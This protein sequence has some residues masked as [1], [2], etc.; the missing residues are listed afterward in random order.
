[1]VLA[2]AGCGG[3]SKSG[4]KSDA[5]NDT[6]KPA[7]DVAI[8]D[9]PL[10]TPDRASDL[11]VP[12]DLAL[13]I[14]ADQAVATPDT[15]ADTSPDTSP[16]SAPAVDA[17]VEAALPDTAPDTAPSLGLTQATPAPALATA[18]LA[19]AVWKTINA[20]DKVVALYADKDFGVIDMRDPKNPQTFGPFATTGKVM[21]MDFDEQRSLLYGV[22]ATGAVFT[23]TMPTASA[24]SIGATLSIPALATASAI[25]RV[26]NWLYVLAGTSLQ[27]VQMSLQGTLV[28][29]LV[30]GTVVT[31]PQTAAFLGGGA[32]LL[33]LGQ[34]AG[35]VEAWSV[36][37]QSGAIANAGSFAAGGPLVAMLPKA[38]KLM[39]L[40][41]GLGLRV[42][43][44]ATPA[45]PV[46]IAKVAELSDPVDARLLGRMLVVA[47]A[48]GLVSAIDLSN[49][50]APKAIASNPGTLPTSLAV[51]GGNVVLGSG[52]SAQ[53]LGV[54]PM[55]SSALPAIVQKAMPLN[56]VVP[57]TFNKVIAP[58]S[59]AGVALTC[60]GNAIAGS[61]QL[62]PDGKT[63]LWKPAASLPTSAACS[64]SLAGITDVSGVALATSAGSYSFTTA[65]TAPGKVE[66]AA[67]SKFT[68]K[69]DGRFTDFAGDGGLSGEWSDVQP[70]QGMYTYFYADFDGQYLWILNDWYKSEE[71]IDPDCYNL[72]S[73]GLG[74]N[75]WQIRAYG[76]QHVEAYKDGVLVDAQSGG[77]EGASG[78]AA[79][80]NV[81]TP[82]T[83]WE[84]KIPTVGGEFSSELHDPTSDSH[85]GNLAAEP[86]AG[87]GLMANL[88]GLSASLLTPAA[89]VA[90]TL[91]S[92]AAAATGVSVTPALTWTDSN[93]PNQFVWYIIELSTATDFTANLVVGSASQKT[94]TP[95]SRALKGETPY[96]W[97]VTSYNL[98]G[99]AKS[100]VGTFTT[101]VAPEPGQY[102][103]SVMASGNGTI[104][105]TPA[106]I[107]CPTIAC[108]ATLAAKS[109][110][111]LTATPA[112][113]WQFSGW[114]GTCSSSSATMTVTMID[115]L[116]CMALFTQIPTTGLVAVGVSGAGTVSSTPAGINAC[117]S[118]GGT[119]TA[120]FALNTSVQ[121]TATAQ[122]GA[123]FTGWYGCS[124][125]PTATISVNVSAAY[126]TCVAM[127]S[128]NCGG[129]GQACCTSG[130]ACTT[131]LTCTAG[132]CQVTSTTGPSGATTLV[133]NEVGLY[134]AVDA[135]NVYWSNLGFGSI[136]KVPLAGG[137]VT[138]LATGQ[139]SPY[140]VVVD[141]NNVYWVT[142][143]TGKTDGTVMSVPI[144][145]GT[146]TTL[147]SAQGS[148]TGIAVRGG[149]VYWAVPLPGTINRVP[150]AGGTIET[151]ATSE[152]LANDIDVDDTSVYWLNR[153]SGKVQQ[154]AITGGAVTTLASG[155]TT[156]SGI[157]LDANNV[158]WVNQG[159]S[160]GNDGSVMS[161]PKA[162]GA[163]V[164][165]VSNVG[166]PQYITTD[167][168]D[169]Y[170]TNG[171]TPG[172]LKKIPVGGGTA[173][174]VATGT[175]YLF[176]MAVDSTSVY[177]TGTAV[178]KIAK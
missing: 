56:G 77:V 53:I 172:A 80:P 176:G 116:S 88:G 2:W 38:S 114:Y 151:L 166:K 73:F 36:N 134:M 170:F 86:S 105:S 52:L 160:S 118:A 97:R 145:G 158:Y 31:L 119:C 98:G 173:T 102:N 131:G 156:P 75:R 174:T 149:Y 49:Y 155:Q 92:P 113:G 11:T 4:G 178:F 122:A 162:G 159:S 93:Q 37:P 138:T 89:P 61:S 141:A 108:N 147:A 67:K 94:W 83:I 28:S 129:Q 63:L 58:A 121:L 171:L 128:A 26:A 135:T 30:A 60:A 19:R 117:A 120:N 139:S 95:P 81:S 65:A 25:T 111:S 32:S 69:V 1:V 125:S 107:D 84:L 169:V 164:T 45:T 146:P 96:Y 10:T 85:C 8:A 54:P 43:D 42:L 148:P 76:D 124:T 57:I 100:A 140:K 132:T 15:A 91:V 16:D 3:G 87:S 62:S 40:V 168:I 115:N 104:V 109:T 112:A 46:E 144:A 165:L 127:F 51:V 41:T 106:A 21:A 143:G 142:Y 12:P 44:F 48:R 18:T 137:T 123:T 82:H 90:P 47:L 59:L 23:A 24:V 55:V 103:L 110:V 153:L 99:S 7:V 35:A 68:H 74:P 14:A 34:S 152:A 130:S 13:D 133:P 27:P 72:F 66:N 6:A 126:Q 33:Y 22:D 157:A 136:K 150:V 17:A 9:R 175:S 101:A 29:S 50:A 78:F 71:K 39:L 167:G 177:W 161:V 154:I 64:L 163:P 70:M 5:G 79:S 20:G